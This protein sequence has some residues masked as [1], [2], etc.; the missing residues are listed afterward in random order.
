MGGQARDGAADEAAHAH[1]ARDNGAVA[2]DVF[3]LEGEA[4]LEQDD[5]HR[6]R[7][8]GEEQFTEEIVRPQPAAH[9]TQQDACTQQEDN[10]G[11]AHPPSQQLGQHAG[12]GNVYQ[13]ADRGKRHRRHPRPLRA[14]GII[15]PCCPRCR[16]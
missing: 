9:R 1:H 12:D 4:A 6:Q 3:Q 10:G 13:R 5:G 7:Y 8:E 14:A 2:P 11:Q 16:P 15:S